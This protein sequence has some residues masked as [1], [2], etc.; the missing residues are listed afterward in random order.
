VV[1][2]DVPPNCT[3]VGIPARILEDSAPGDDQQSFVDHNNRT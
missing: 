2:N 3:A 1:L